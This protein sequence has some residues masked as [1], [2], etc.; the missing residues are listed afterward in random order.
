M[1]S[2]LAIM[3]R[4]VCGCIKCVCMSRYG[5]EGEKGNLEKGLK[6]NNNEGGLGFGG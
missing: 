3:S 5:K 6:V 4:A 1:I 2:E